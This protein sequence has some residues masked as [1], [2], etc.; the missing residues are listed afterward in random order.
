[1]DSHNLMYLEQQELAANLRRQQEQQR[2]E[3]ERER[4]LLEDEEREQRAAQAAAKP[5]A[6]EEQAPE[7]SEPLAKPS[8]AGLWTWF[9]KRPKTDDESDDED[10]APEGGRAQSECV[11]HAD[12]GAG[13]VPWL[14]GLAIAA[15]LGFFGWQSFRSTPAP[16]GR[17]LET[18]K[19]TADLP[20]ARPDEGLSAPSGVQA[21]V[22]SG[23]PV[24][25]AQPEPAATAATDPIAATTPAQAP[26]R[27][28]EPEGSDASAQAPATASHETRTTA[29][30]AP[31]A[32]VPVAAEPSETER[33]RTRVAELEASVARLLAAQPQPQ[34]REAARVSAPAAQRPH[35]AVARASAQPKAA[36]T[37]APVAA[38]PAF[39]PGLEPV[40][41]SIDVWDGR[42]SVVI[43]T[44]GDKRTVILQPGDSL[45]G[46][47]LRSVD[48][49]AGKATFTAGNG[50]PITFDVANGNHVGSAAP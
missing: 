32:A 8:K 5:A 38:Q 41:L 33:L 15:V 14:I 36:P 1:M 34:P 6:P 48:V 21:G 27:L 2:R 11:S 24:A 12:G 39:P 10:D 40:L 4:Q 50:A 13:V 28:A 19:P 45:N 31:A 30:N 47:Q 29:D 43:G 3:E 17:A 25:S 44:S 22:E 16:V 42:P 46:V 26:S 23:E 9:G 35:A 49:A 18:P 20:L 37:P 7:S